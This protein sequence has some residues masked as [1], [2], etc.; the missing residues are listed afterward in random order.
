MIH[1]FQN[2]PIHCTPFLFYGRSRK[3]FSAARWNSSRA[4]HRFK[5]H[6]HKSSRTR[7]MQPQTFWP[8]RKI[9]R[10]TP[11]CFLKNRERTKHSLWSRLC[12]KFVG[13]T[14]CYKSSKIAKENL[15]YIYISFAKKN[16]NSY[17]SLE[18]NIKHD[19]INYP[20]VFSLFFAPYYV[21]SFLSKSAK[22]SDLQHVSRKII[23]PRAII[24]SELNLHRR[25]VKVS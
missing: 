11:S 2:I 6:D 3:G 25:K 22:A 19:T 1:F 21:V 23:A 8:R 20:M 10:F 5:F 12:E 13:K 24:V 15:S 17:Q 18:V 7:R 9:F 14:L 16:D 4:Q